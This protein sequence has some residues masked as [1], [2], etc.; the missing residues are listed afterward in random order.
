MKSVIIIPYFGKFPTFFQYFLNSCKYNK[1]F[2]WLIYTNDKTKFDYPSNVKVNYISFDEFK[3]F[4]QSKFDFKIE[5]IRPHKLCDFKVAYGYI[6]EDIIKDYDYWAH[7]DLDV[8]YGDLKAFLNPLFIQNFD[9]IYS[10]GHL[11]FYKNTELVNRV[12]KNKING[13]EVYKRI[14]STDKS[15]AFDEWHCVLGSI[16]HL[17]RNSNLLFFENNQCANIDSVFNGFKLSNYI[18]NFGNY[19]KDNNN[20]NIF[21]YEKGKLTR[22]Y[23]LFQ[24]VNFEKYPYIHLHKREMF[25]NSDNYDNYLI[26]PNKFINVQEINKKSILKLSSTSKFNKQYFKV[27]YLNLKYRLKQLLKR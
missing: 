8:V 25:G 10:L 18:I 24:K 21:H 23:F 15:Y 12:F 6:F 19:A 4:V 5:I 22:Y 3:D 17:F 2:D 27:K 7:G 11:S 1:D 16:N 9:K 13:D 26:I 14:F 20:Q